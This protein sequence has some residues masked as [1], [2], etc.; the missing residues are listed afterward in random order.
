MHIT[1]PSRGRSSTVSALAWAFILAALAT[2]V[3]AGTRVVSGDLP[4]LD[5]ADHGA[6]GLI[7]GF[8]WV[9]ERGPAILT[10]LL[11]G[12]L[13]TLLIS[14]ALLLRLSWARRAFLGL[15]SFGFVAT[16]MATAVTPMVFALMP[17]EATTGAFIPDDPL[18]GM[19]G[20]LGGMIV[21]ATALTALFAWVA[22]KLTRP[23]IKAEFEP[24]PAD[25]DG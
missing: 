16:L 4:A 9:L 21:L 10:L 15:M 12:A 25:T 13:A 5:V 20:L 22:W 2:L 1:P 19:V 8:A 17:D 7:A 23:Q 14:V 11:A 24:S 6:G 18:A 3:F